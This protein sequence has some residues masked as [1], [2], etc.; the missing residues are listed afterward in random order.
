MPLNLLFQSIRRER[1]RERV[2]FD[3]IHLV[4]SI[5][6]NAG[7]CV[8]ISCT[9]PAVCLAALIMIMVLTVRSSPAILKRRPLKTLFLEQQERR[10]GAKEKISMPKM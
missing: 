8:V 9:S 2:P 1:E 6:Q 10:S 3:C 7:S 5:V 4:D